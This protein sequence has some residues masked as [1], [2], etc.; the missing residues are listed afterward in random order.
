VYCNS[1]QSIDERIVFFRFAKPQIL[2]GVSTPQVGGKY[3]L[4]PSGNSP[5]S[6][7]GFLEN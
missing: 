5:G 4:L 7:T 3:Y 2:S 1:N 6:I